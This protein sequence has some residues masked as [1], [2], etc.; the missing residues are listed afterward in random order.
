MAFLGMPENQIDVTR[1]DFIQWVD[2][3]IHF[4]C[5]EQLSGLD[6]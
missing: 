6:L 1:Q 3:Y 4:P 2:R 5:K